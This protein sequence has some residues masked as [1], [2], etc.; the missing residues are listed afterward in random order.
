MGN[1]KAISASLPKPQERTFTRWR[2][3]AYGHWAH[4]GQRS[5]ISPTV[6]L[7]CFKRQNSLSNFSNGQNALNPCLTNISVFRWNSCGSQHDFAVSKQGLCACMERE[8]F[9]LCIVVSETSLHNPQRKFV[10]NR[11]W[12]GLFPGKWKIAFTVKLNVFP[13]VFDHEFT[14]IS[15]ILR[16]SQIA[17]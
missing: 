13:F 7:R 3:T 16:L 12:K 2:E 10:K 15:K 17:M 14:I 11:K 4:P 1:K 8:I 9:C 5:H 6:F